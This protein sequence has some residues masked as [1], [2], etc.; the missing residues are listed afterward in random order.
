MPRHPAVASIWEVDQ[1]SDTTIYVIQEFVDGSPL[2]QRL[3]PQVQ[4]DLREVLEIV[5]RVAFGLQALHDA[6]IVHRDV[7]PSNILLCADDNPKLID[8][9]PRADDGKHGRWPK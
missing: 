4:G 6:H 3:R 9:V 8:F 5:E 2:S 7:K 1:F